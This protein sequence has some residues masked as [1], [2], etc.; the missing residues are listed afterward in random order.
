MLSA[1]AMPTPTLFGQKPSA[2]M[3][4]QLSQILHCIDLFWVA[5]CHY[6][7]LDISSLSTK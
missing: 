3:V 5:K 4:I 2:H 6:H 7:R 1:K